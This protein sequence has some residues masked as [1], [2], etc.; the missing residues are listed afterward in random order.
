MMDN[1]NDGGEFGTR[2]IGS[3]KLVIVMT[4]SPGSMNTGLAG[5]PAGRQ[6]RR[7]ASP[8]QDRGGPFALP[9]STSF[10]FALLSV[11][12]VVT[13][14][15]VYE[16]IYL[17]T[18]RGGALIS[19]I[20]RCTSQAQASHPSGAIAL[21]NAL[22]QAAVCYSGGQ[23][24]EAGWALLG[25][26]ALIVV[27]GVIF[28]AQPRWY[29]WRKD[30]TELAGPDTADLVARLEGLR[31][32]AGTGPVVWLLQ[33]L[34][35]RLSAFAFGL[36]GRRRVAVTG[37]AAIAAVKKPAE[38]DAVV[39]HELS[40]IKNRDIDQTYLAL[41]I[42]RAFMVA[43][44][45]PL[46]VVL[47]VS[48]V[49]G[50]PQLLIWRIVVLALIVYSLR[51][52]ILRSR[53]FDADAR[54]RQLDP[55]IALDAV[56]ADLPA[57]AGRRAWHLGWTHPSGQQR[58]AALR[59]PAPLYRFGF[60]DGLSIGLVAALGATA[61]HEIVTL[62]STT[63][64][65]HWAVPAIVFAAFAGPALV[66]AMWRRQLREPDTGLVKGWAAGLGVGLGL[67]LGPVLAPMAAYD[68]ALAPDHASLASFGVLAVWIAGVV[69]VFAPFPVWVGHWADAWQ[70]RGDT[71]AP[72]VPARGAMVAAAAAAWA[73]MA[74]GLYLLLEN[75]TGILGQSNAADAWHGLPE[76]L[77]G[78]A[79][80]IG[81][82]WSGWLVVLLVVGMPLAAT[83]AYRRR[84]RP[85]DAADP[86]D[87]TARHRRWLVP[88]LAGL[89]GCLATIALMLAING[90]THARIAEVVR[91]S[92]D[93][94]TGLYF[95]DEQAIVV[96]AVV[97]ALITAARVRSAAGLAVS[98]V[99][100]AVVAAAGGLA[101][102]SM[103][104]IGDCFSSLSLL[105]AHPPAGGCLTSPDTVALRTVV[106]GA[107]LVS[108][109]FV[110]AVYAAR[111]AL[112]RRIRRERRPA[113]GTAIGWAAA[114]VAALAALTGTA[115]WAPSASAQGVKP[116][117]SIGSDG[118]IRGYGY[119]VR[120]IPAW[121]ASP[122]G[123]GLWEL[124]FSEDGGQIN[125]L[126]LA[127]NH[128]VEAEDWSYLL[129]LGAHQDSLDGAPGLLL[130][131]SDQAAHVLEQW[132]V[133]RTSAFYV[134]TLY[135]APGWPGDS[136]YLESKYA[137]TLRSW[138]WTS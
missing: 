59:D 54:A 102:A 72:R 25:V 30:L 94:L 131:H 127:G 129:R 28:L 71:T 85:G 128:A 24:A 11:A 75:V 115:L 53:E 34:N 36:P 57:R 98:V 133:V 50:E 58:A 136:P 61:A 69:V 91:W 52:A 87:T 90:L 116:S 135:G 32:R 77:R 60:W 104:N 97:C 92:L 118:W 80:V 121:Y 12:V 44:L 39:L 1:R 23:R 17:A 81:Q 66:V 79:I 123:K 46:A 67:A 76:Y 120:L 134:L 124:T 74:V 70:Q 15:F 51:N 126:A 6:D 65:I 101:L 113:S 33:P 73:V 111:M 29:C 108:I 38:F 41:A 78:T 96:I 3:A 119:E 106:L 8:A 95:F 93:F 48:R 89:A 2:S 37:G 137:A 84:R 42:W 117:G 63:V 122:G 14:F 100:G 105:Y 43:A 47:I 109:L 5:V 68:R 19:L 103:L 64:G 82:A 62:L 138:R 114:T 55:A 31:E 27:A 16:G 40:H 88:V 13:S 4:S 83:V 56:F 125:L 26:C 99:V 45:L 18:P 86:A 130:V 7:A 112:R 22:G 35:D 132:L 21:A 49:L 10:R 20:D 9:V 110:P 107:A